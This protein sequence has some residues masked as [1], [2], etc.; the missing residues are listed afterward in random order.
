MTLRWKMTLG[1]GLKGRGVCSVVASKSRVEFRLRPTPNGA[2]GALSLAPFSLSEYQLASPRHYDCSSFYCKSC[3]L[4]M[5][6]LRNYI[7]STS[8][9]KK[10]F[11]P[12]CPGSLGCDQDRPPQ[13]RKHISYLQEIRL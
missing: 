3:M 7:T 11:W 12:S 2:A 1:V 10:K 8:L 4:S 9:C 5:Y 13:P 6:K